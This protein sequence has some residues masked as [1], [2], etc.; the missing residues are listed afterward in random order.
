MNLPTMLLATLG[1]YLACGVVFAPPFV[2]WGVGRGDPHARSG[3]WG[4]RL[5][6]LPGVVFLWPLL[7]RRWMCGA[8][9]PPAERNAHRCAVAAR[10]RKEPE[11]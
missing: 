3:T 4:F 6:L 2:L 10:T 8:Q 1:I 7:L 5:L 11:S 9:Q